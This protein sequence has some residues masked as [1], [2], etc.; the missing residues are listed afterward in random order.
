MKL[1]SYLRLQKITVPTFAKQLGVRSRM[2]VHRYVTGERLPRPAI[3]NKISEITGG[4]VQPSDFYATITNP[5]T[6]RPRVIKNPDRDNKRITTAQTKAKQPH[7]MV[8]AMVSGMTPSPVNNAVFA[9]TG[10]IRASVG[11]MLSPASTLA[12][13]TVWDMVDEAD[14]YQEKDPNA[15]YDSE[16]LGPLS[17][18]LA[19]AFALVAPQAQL[20]AG[21]FYWCNRPTSAAKI[22]REA[23]S[24]L[25][26]RGEPLLHYPNV[27]EG[28][29]ANS[30]SDPACL[31]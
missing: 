8:L 10:H 16:G 11:A 2:T 27:R 17:P 26:R 24:I 18:V 25:A 23:N 31:N 3:M 12:G 13:D 1:E 19:R 5:T 30:I 9:S 4:L 29:G 14:T 28:G 6:K 22:I 21:Q 7:K 15:P 20:K